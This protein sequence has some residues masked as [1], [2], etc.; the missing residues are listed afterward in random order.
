MAIFAITEVT[1]TAGKNPK[2]KE[3]ND[4]LGRMTTIFKRR[5]LVPDVSDITGLLVINHDID[6]HPRKR[7]QLYAGA[8]EEIVDAAKEQNIGLLSTIA[9]YDITLAAK[10]GV[11][12]KEEA[13]G[14]IKQFG[15][16][17]LRLRR[18][19]AS[20]EDNNPQTL[21]PLQSICRGIVARSNR[22]DARSG[23]KHHAWSRYYLCAS[24]GSLILSR[25]SLW[26]IF[27]TKK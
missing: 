6:T 27:T 1:G 25:T 14:M 22:T 19:K 15:R 11:I 7:P 8:M 9:L 13:R 26:S 16:I 10:D 4:L 2:I 23:L 3:Y 17:E 24:I 5:D 18:K 12:T 20:P 21:H